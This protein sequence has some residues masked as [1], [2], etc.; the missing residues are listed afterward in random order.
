MGYEEEGGEGMS[1]MGLEKPTEPVLENGTMRKRTA[2][3]PSEVHS[4]H[5]KRNKRIKEMIEKR[6]GTMWEHIKSLYHTAH[7]E[8]A[9]AEGMVK[10][11]ALD[12][13][14]DRNMSPLP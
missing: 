4:P 6:A 9:D 10:R 12:R 11:K 8:K 7:Q 13:G 2:E 5:P 1:A 14:C 3:G